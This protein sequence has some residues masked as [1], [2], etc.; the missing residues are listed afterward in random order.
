MQKF[1]LLTALYILCSIGANPQNQKWDRPMQ[2]VKCSIDVKADMFTASTFMELEFYNP[3][4][5]EIEGLYRFELRPGQAITAFQLDLFGKYRDGTIEEKWK[6]TNAYNTIVGKRIDPALLTMES[7]N[8]YSLRIYPVPANGTRKVTMTIQQLLHSEHNSLQYY[9]PL[10][11]QD[12]VDTFTLNIQVESGN[13]K[14]VSLPGLIDGLA[15]SKSMKLFSLTWKMTK[16]RLNLPVIFSIPIADSFVYCTKQS[17]DKTHFAMRLKP[18]AKAEYELQPRHITVL[19]DASASAVKRDL[20]K[21]IN[22]LRQFIAYHG[23]TRLTLIPFNH[24]II[25][26]VI[27]EQPVTS[28]NRWQQYL[29]NLEYSGATQLGCLDLRDMT[30]DIFLLFSDGNNTYGKSRPGTGKALLYAVY[31]ANGA[32]KALLHEIVGTS[33]GRVIDLKKTTLS[34]AVSMHSKAQN[35]L[36]G[37]SSASGKT[38]VEQNFPAR[39]KESIFIN[40]T[41][42]TSSD[43]LF[44]HYG[45]N[46][47]ILKIEKVV[48]NKKNCPSS[49]LDR[50]PMLEHF[51]SMIRSNSWEDILDFGLVEKVVTPNTA[52][53]VLERIEDYIKYNITPPAE[54]EEECEKRG[55]VKKDSRRQ[56]LQVR[57]ADEFEIISEVVKAYNNRLS[58]WDKNVQ[59]ISFTKNEFIN[60]KPAKQ[61]WVESKENATIYGMNS[62]E[63]SMAGMTPGILFEESNTMNEVLITTAF[64]I[65]KRKAMNSYATTLHANEIGP[66]QTIEQALQ[67]RVPGVYVTTNTGSSTLRI[68]GSSTLN[69]KNEPLYMLDG[70]PVYGNI[71]DYVSMSEIENITVIKD[72]A[73]LAIYGSRGANGVIV[74]NTK[75]GIQQTRRNVFPGPYRLSDM[76]D[77][78]YLKEIKSAGKDEK[79]SV[80]NRLR[81][82]HEN[83]PGFYLDMAQHFFE[84]GNAH[85]A[86]DILMNAIEVANGSL[87]VA[88]AAG[89]ILEKNKQYS[90]AIEWYR[91]LLDENP[92]NLYLYRDLA[93]VYYQNGQIQDAL[94]LMYSAVMRDFKIMGWS[95]VPYKALILSE[96]NA[97]ISLHRNDLDISAIPPA[98]LKPMPV[99]LRIVLDGNTWYSGNLIVRQP[100]GEECT[101]SKPISKSGGYLGFYNNYW[102][103]GTVAEYQIKNAGTGKYKIKLNYFGN[104]Y[105]NHGF[106]IPAYIRIVT[107]RSFGKPGQ[108]IQIENVVMDNQYGEV[109]IAEVKW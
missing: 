100:D 34:N 109:E 87:Q 5:S 91:F 7:P 19:W 57:Q 108:S 92:Y 63:N 44:L 81:M 62:M 107:F 106:K 97:I 64:G 23:I 9:L 90:D 66:Y 76:E 104:N 105:Y 78:D 26:K 98:L 25:D 60:E 82:V 103:Y 53:I 70:I 22:F 20:N 83:D 88:R 96:M 10:N 32:N 86:K 29:N 3:N 16:I 54:L 27:F 8:R 94:D 48:L 12:V 79:L 55:F 85:Q 45:N 13:H 59:S 24:R 102:N 61:S 47:R 28:R 89:F 69:H 1:N 58:H 80:Y 51:E 38:I 49:A 52:Y 42:N 74:V 30:D 95:N 11:I 14:P 2:L 36:L 72:G 6:A 21:E 17:N 65:T 56:R 93:W 35:W 46:D 39:L 18:A 67:G 101:F 84:T 73:A 75:R 33:G 4:N 77:V 50:I 68:R 31:S 41:M 15:F 37:I 43:T 40:G 71:N 99:D